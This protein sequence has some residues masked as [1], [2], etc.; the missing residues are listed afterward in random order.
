MKRR[1]NL[2]ARLVLNIIDIKCLINFELSNRI[3][4]KSA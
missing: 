3:G 1:L 2:P 4:Y